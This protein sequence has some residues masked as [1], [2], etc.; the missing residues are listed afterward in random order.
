MNE[1]IRAITQLV[2]NKRYIVDLQKILDR[3]DLT[4]NE[5]QTMQ[6][7]VRDLNQVGIDKQQAEVKGR[8][9]WLGK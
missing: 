4:H 2:G 6:H 5:R 1:L 3:L 9:P 7:L 8:S